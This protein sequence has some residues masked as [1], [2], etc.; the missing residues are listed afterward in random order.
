[1]I[2]LYV[3]YDED[4]KHPFFYALDESRNACA[5]VFIQEE[6]KTKKHPG[7][8]LFKI[9]LDLEYFQGLVKNLENDACCGF[10]YRHHW[11]ED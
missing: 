9:D 6:D 4:T 2:E 10:S 8:R 5:A 11:D 7:Q 3:G 1:M